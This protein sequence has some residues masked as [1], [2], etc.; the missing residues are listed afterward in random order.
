MNAE[1]GVDV[2]SIEAAQRAIELIDNAITIVSSERS[3]LGAIQNRLEYTTNNLRTVKTSPPRNRASA[4][5]TWPK[6]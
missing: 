6:K 5:W 1:R 3:K 2:M 4:T